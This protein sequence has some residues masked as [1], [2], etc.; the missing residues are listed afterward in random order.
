MLTVQ[1]MIILNKIKREPIQAIK[2]SSQPSTTTPTSTKKSSKKKTTQLPTKL[3][4]KYQK[5]QPFL[6]FTFKQLFKRGSL[7]V[8]RFHYNKFCNYKHMVCLL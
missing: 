6:N 8:S 1:M 5:L 4:F 3:D 7:Y 2:A